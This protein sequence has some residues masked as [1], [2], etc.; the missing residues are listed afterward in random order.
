[1]LITASIGYHMTHQ[2]RCTN[3]QAQNQNEGLILQTSST[4]TW[5]GRSRRVTPNSMWQH[6]ADAE[7]TAQSL[8]R[9]DRIGSEAKWV[10]RTSQDHMIFTWDYLKSHKSSVASP[11]V[12]ANSM[13]HRGR[14]QSFLGGNTSIFHGCFC[15]LQTR[16]TYLHSGLR[17]SIG[18][19]PPL[20][21]TT[22][23]CVCVIKMRIFH[24][25]LLVQVGAECLG[26]CLFWIPF[27]FI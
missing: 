1:M 21:S 7:K 8:T 3:S 25:D 10:T 17:A 5:C 23:V 13:C 26:I 19:V 20:C 24:F 27:K 2:C 18:L 9:I 12:T 14:A 16:L 15:N 22:C 11:I 6:A 4:F